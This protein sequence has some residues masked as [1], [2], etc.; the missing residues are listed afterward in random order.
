MEG[1]KKG[2]QVNRDK[3]TGVV[4]PTQQLLYSSHKY[5]APWWLQ[6]KRKLSLISLY[7]CQFIWYFTWKEPDLHL[8]TGW[9][10][11][12]SCTS[13]QQKKKTELKSL[14]TP[15]CQKVVVTWAKKKKKSFS[16]FFH[17]ARTF[18]QGKGPN[19]AAETLSLLTWRSGCI[20]RNI[21]GANIYVHCNTW[22]RK[23]LLTQRPKSK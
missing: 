21:N 4:A 7:L 22:K 5:L 9:A 1:K 19:F 12:A 2:D 20:C 18:F 13:S 14:R 6:C 15:K 10:I 11:S 16:F 8:C 23:M 3:V 17:P